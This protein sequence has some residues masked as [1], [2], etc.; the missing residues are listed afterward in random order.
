MKQLSIRIIISSFFV[1]NSA[2]LLFGQ[3]KMIE[4]M[5]TTFDSIPLI[6]ASIEVKSTKELVLTDTLGMFDSFLRSEG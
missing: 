4:G 1:F 5:V 2:I 6:G 3:E